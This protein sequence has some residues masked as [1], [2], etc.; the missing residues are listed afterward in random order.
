MCPYAPTGI[1]QSPWANIESLL[2][3]DASLPAGTPVMG[4]SISGASSTSALNMSDAEREFLLDLALL[5]SS[6]D[7]QN[8]PTAGSVLG[9]LYLRNRLQ[10]ASAI[11]KMHPSLAA[12][13]RW[14]LAASLKHAGL[15]DVART[16]AQ[17]LMEQLA[18]SD[19]LRASVIFIDSHEVRSSSYPHFHLNN[20][21]HS[22]IF[23]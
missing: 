1:T 3:G 5:R 23:V 16:L 14:A 2:G 11:Q 15:I 10:P 18:G 8:S 9:R 22:L 19:T 20:P 7:G 13:S 17:K 4:Q 12:A 6:D 21:T